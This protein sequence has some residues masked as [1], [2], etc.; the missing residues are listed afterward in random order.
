MFSI[1]RNVVPVVCLAYLSGMG[2]LAFGLPGILGVID[3]SDIIH[4]FDH[5]KSS[6]VS[7]LINGKSRDFTKLFKYFNETKTSASNILAFS[8]LICL[9]LK[10]FTCYYFVVIYLIISSIIFICII[11]YFISIIIPQTS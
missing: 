8:L 9:I 1:L 6:S 2:G 3:I 4:S 5:E 11:I 10:I 7:Q